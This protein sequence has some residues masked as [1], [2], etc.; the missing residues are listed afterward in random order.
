MLL[1]TASVEAESIDFLQKYDNIIKNNLEDIVYIVQQTEELESD[2]VIGRG[3]S[4]NGLVHYPLHSGKRFIGYVT[5]YYDENKVLQWSFS[6]LIPEH[7]LSVMKSSDEYRVEYYSY[8]NI[9]EKSKKT[10]PFIQT[11]K[12]VRNPVKLKNPFIPLSSNTRIIP[13]RIVEVQGSKPWCAAFAA[14]AIINTKQTNT[15]TNAYAIMRH[16]YSQGEIPYL[17]QFALTDNQILEYSK[18][19]G[20]KTRLTGTLSMDHVRSQ[21]TN[22]SPIYIAGNRYSNG[23][24]KG[25][26]AFVISGYDVGSNKFYAW[27]PWGQYV[28]FSA[29]SKSIPANSYTYFWNKSVTGWSK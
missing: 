20:Y 26:H 7:A 22:Y 10:V 19:R 3:L 21:I 13:L 24:V 28:W 6:G 29:S 15:T 11:T 4:N 8:L 16:F 2:V 18:Y 14:S 23:Q 25:R 27:N 9:L 17:D 5:V 12:L 1:T